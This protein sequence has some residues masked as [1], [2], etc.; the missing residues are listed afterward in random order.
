MKQIILPPNNEYT[1]SGSEWITTYQTM[2]GENKEQ[3]LIIDFVTKN[4]D[5]YVRVQELHTTNPYIQWFCVENV[6]KAFELVEDVKKC[7]SI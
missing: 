5:V 3:E 1:L 4:G 2:F 7:L 6:D